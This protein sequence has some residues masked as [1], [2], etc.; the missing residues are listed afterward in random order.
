MVFN[1]FKVFQGL[2]VSFLS[3]LWLFQGF[4]GF[5]NVS[6]CFEFFLENV[7][8]FLGT[9]FLGFGCFCGFFFFRRSCVSKMFFDCCKVFIVLNVFKGFFL[10]GWRGRREGYHWCSKV[11][12]TKLFKDVFRS[13]QC[14]S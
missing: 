2:L 8:V 14:F 1:V 4:Q 9:F 11:N 13:F 5:F 7:H 12:F 3:F 6:G 10:G